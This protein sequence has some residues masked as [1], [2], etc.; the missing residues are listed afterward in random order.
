MGRFVKLPAVLK[1]VTKTINKCLSIVLDTETMLTY[2]S[3]TSPT[4]YIVEATESWDSGFFAPINPKL[5]EVDPT[6]CTR[7]FVPSSPP[8]KYPLDKLIS[9]S[10]FISSVNQVVDTGDLWSDPY[11]WLPEVVKHFPVLLNTE[12]VPARPD[13]WL[14]YVP[15]RKLLTRVIWC[16][17]I[18]G[19]RE[20][21]FLG[22]PATPILIAEDVETLHGQNEANVLRIVSKIQQDMR[23]YFNELVSNTENLIEL[24]TIET[25]TTEEAKEETEKPTE[26]RAEE[27]RVEKGEEGGVEVEFHV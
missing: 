5:I 9:I 7:S 26:A 14:V 4:L 18:I 6:L 19:I 20:L 25:T 2:I 1:T 11:S 21:R 16:R 15:K 12:Q 3:N 24:M 13:Q 17:R 22:S 23:Y 27:K 10:R 8:R